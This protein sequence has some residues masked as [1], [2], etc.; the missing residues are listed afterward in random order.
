MSIVI[1]VEPELSSQAEAV[2]KQLG[3]SMNEVVDS[4]LRYVVVRKKLPE[5][6]N[7]PPIL[8]IDEISLD[9]LDLLTQEAFEAIEN[10]NYDLVDEAEQI[11]GIDSNNC[12]F[13]VQLSGFAFDDLKAIQTYIEH[14]TKSSEIA[15]NQIYRLMMA[16]EALAIF[17]E[18]HRSRMKD[19]NGRKLRFFSVDNY[20]ML[21]SIEEQNHITDI[22]RVFYSRRHSDILI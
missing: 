5:F 15:Y 10:G 8:C 2:F 9:E 12:G 11:L 7:M 4:V 18:M 20:V 16:S 6:L 1:Q 17:P 19:R 3:I 14:T 22:L 13:T 21:Y